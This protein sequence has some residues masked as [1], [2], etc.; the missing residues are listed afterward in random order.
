MEKDEDT[1]RRARERT[2]DEDTIRRRAMLREREKI[3]EGIEKEERKKGIYR[4]RSR[5]VEGDADTP[6]RRAKGD[7]ASSLVAGAKS[8]GFLESS[9]SIKMPDLDFTAR[10][11][12][13]K[14]R[15]EGVGEGEGDEDE[16]RKKIRQVRESHYL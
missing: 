1:P 2:E 3:D 10:L 11:N 4:E 13:K 15:E 16:G 14:E 5:G 6:R 9:N 7:L 12:E 8:Q